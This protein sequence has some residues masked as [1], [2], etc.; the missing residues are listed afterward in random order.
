MGRRWMDICTGRCWMGRW[1]QV[2]GWMSRR[3]MVRWMVDGSVDGG[4]TGRRWM[5]R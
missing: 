5:D 2:D 1:G 3:W 4:W